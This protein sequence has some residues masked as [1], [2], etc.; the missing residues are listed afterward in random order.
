[1]KNFLSIC[2]RFLL[3]SALLLFSVMADSLFAYGCSHI[4][5]QTALWPRFIRYV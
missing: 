5:T 3:V 1:M 4:H 2:I